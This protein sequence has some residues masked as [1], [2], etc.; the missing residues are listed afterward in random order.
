[1]S[2]YNLITYSHNYSKTSADLWQYY[3]DEPAL[4]DAIAINSFATSSYNSASFK[5]KQKT[6]GKTASIGLK[7]SKYICH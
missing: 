2:M 6:T 3:R 1:M 5:F 4:T 7:M